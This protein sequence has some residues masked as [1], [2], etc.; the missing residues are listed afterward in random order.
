L[1]ADWQLAL[2]KQV[3]HGELR[4]VDNIASLQVDK[5][6]LNIKS[7]LAYLGEYIEQAS[8]ID[9]ESGELSLELNLLY[10]LA[11]QSMMFAGTVSSSEIAGKQEDILFDGVEFNSQFN[12]SIDKQREVTIDKDEQQLKIKNLFIGVPIQALKIDARMQNGEPVID[13]FKARLLGGRLDFA[14][15]SVNAPSQTTINLSGISLTEIIK[16]SAYPEIEGK[17]LIDVQLPLELTDN[18]PEINAGLISARAPGGYIKVP[19]NTVITAMGRANPAFFLTMQLLS[20]FQFDT[21]QGKIAYTSDG[22]S[23]L[24]VEIKGIS[25]TVSGTQPINF[26]YS[27]SENILK[28]LQSLRFNDELLRDIEE[29]Y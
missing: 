6:I 26:N 14:D 7:L 9:I 8:L 23:D 17:G 27:H 21:M 19:E 12:Y 5:K 4:L 22:E 2:L 3:F 10:R 15:F 13:H 20:N 1:Q 16:Y 18:G 28:L 24:N 11:E 29:R 25:P